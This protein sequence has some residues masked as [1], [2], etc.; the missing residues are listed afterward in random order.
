LLAYRVLCAGTL[1]ELGDAHLEVRRRAYEASRRSTAN[2]PSD[3]SRWKK[4]VRPFFGAY[5]ADQLDWPDIM[6]FVDERLAAGLGEQSIR[7]CMNLLGAIYTDLV[8]RHR[9]TGI[10]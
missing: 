1:G 2:Y 6:R 3:I 10:T 7:H 4:H 8:E 9:E 5:R